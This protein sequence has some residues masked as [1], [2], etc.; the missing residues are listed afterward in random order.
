M[1]ATNTLLVEGAFSELAEELAHYIDTVAK[2]EE[3]SGLLA[4]IEPAL[5][6][7]RE[8]E[9]SEGPEDAAI[10]KS[11]DD[12]LRKIVLKAS[13]LNSAPEKEFSAAYNLLISL[14]LSS[15]Q[16]EQLFGR[17]CQ[18]LQQPITSSPTSG[19]SLALSTLTTIFNVLSSTSKARYHVFDTILGLIRSSS[20]ATAFEALIPQL[21]ENVDSWVAAWGLDEDDKESLYTAVAEAAD[22]VGHRD[23]KYKY[24]LHA[25]ETVPVAAAQ[26]AE[27][28]DLAKQVLV[29]ALT[30]PTVTDFN[31]LAASDAVQALRKSDPALFELLEIFSSDDYATYVE[32]TGANSLADLGISVAE[33]SVLETKIRLLT[34]TTIA[35]SATNRS[36]PY[37][38]IA[39]SLSIP[40]E[41]V[42]MWVIDTIRAGLVEGKLSQTKQEFLVQRATY[43]V[44]GE[45]QWAEIQGRL[46]VW[47]RSLESVLTAVR[48]ERER[49]LKEG[50]GTQQEDGQ[51]RANGYQDRRGGGRRQQQS[52][53]IDVGAD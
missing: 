46:T 25:L 10:Q 26:E 21:E 39:S 9:Q 7:I 24:L 44:F 36:V 4:E 1:A 8:S 31:P 17:I 47:R 29:E 5:S 40:A 51:Q 16:P 20:A 53:E 34:L 22:A 35:S 32:F 15:S 42:E 19:A 14:S 18:Y 27:S 12:T 48:S 28:R 37:E 38:A 23:L 33:A 2:A 43:R 11:K 13:V 41:D 3:G 45:K 30:N 52:R 6:T 50:L 49:Y